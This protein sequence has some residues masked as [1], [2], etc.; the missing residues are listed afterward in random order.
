MFFKRHLN[1]L[2]FFIF[3][4][5]VNS[6]AIAA[7]SGAFRVETPDAA[8]MG[9]GSAFVGEA[10]TPAAVYYNPAGLNQID[11]AQ[12]SFGGAFLAPNVDYKPTSGDE[13][14]MRRNQ[15]LIPHVFAVVPV[16]NRVA[17]GLGS[18]AY[19]GLGTEWAQDSPLR[20]DATKSDIL[21]QDYMLTA[22]YQ[23]TDKWSIAA[24]PDNDFSRA[25]KNKKL[26]QAN[27]VD[28]NFQLK[29]K[30]D[31]WGYRL[32]TMYKL[33][34]RHQFGLMYRSRIKH[35]Y[36][37]KAYLDNLNTSPTLAGQGLSSTS[38]QGVFGDTTY[39]TN[40]TEKFT[41]PQSV[42]I[43]YS[44][45]PTAKW[46]FNLD[47]EWMDWSSVEQEAINWTSETDP[48]RLAVLNGGNPAPR[49]WHSVWSQAIGAEYAATDRLRLRGGYFHHD[50]P[51][52]QDTWDPNLPDANSHGFTTGFGFDVTKSLTLDLAY[53]A[54]IYEPRKIDNTVSNAG[55]GSVDG[56]YTQ[57]MHVALM[58]L[59]Y[60]F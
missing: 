7:G 59:T 6:N 57:Y 24:G 41:L 52:P 13:V 5:G 17:V 9:K 26:A 12:I 58:T 15:F 60:K 29:A 39:E 34:E 38:Y 1:F 32:A 19:F 55:G 43:G 42:V 4:V 50:S 53:S 45:K 14:Q 30:D 31:A 21:N 25:N 48:S 47:V 18:T 16:N 2:L 27:G 54:L 28:G 49:D 36:E 23:V 46:T 44:F 40:L 35:E 33:N 20:Y 8:A 11:R 37:G 51:I 22:S 3:L 10:N 56:E